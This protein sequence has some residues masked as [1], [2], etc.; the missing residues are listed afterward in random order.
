MEFALHPVRSKWLL[1]HLSLIVSMCT[2][3]CVHLCSVE[4][5]V[6]SLDIAKNFTLI[7]DELKSYFMGLFQLKLIL[8]Y[9]EVSKFSKNMRNLIKVGQNLKSRY[10][11]SPPL[12]EHIYMVCVTEKQKIKNSLKCA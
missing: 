6:D 9:V 10:L 1:F 7:E 3:S 12:Y 4:S 11:S 5:C 2:C 8:H